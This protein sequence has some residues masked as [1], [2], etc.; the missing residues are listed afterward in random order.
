MTRH[1]AAAR[2]VARAV[3]AVAA[4]AAQP[5]S[6]EGKPTF[7]QA[8]SLQPPTTFPVDA[9]RLTFSVPDAG[10]EDLHVPADA[11]APPPPLT[12]AQYIRALDL[13][14]S[15]AGFERGSS[16]GAATA[17]AAAATG[18]AAAAAAATAVAGTSSTEVPQGAECQQMTDADVR[19]LRYVLL[20]SLAGGG[21]A[22]DFGAAFLHT[23]MAAA[24]DVKNVMPDSHGGAAAGETSALT[25]GAFH[26]AHAPP[27]APPL[28]TRAAP[29]LS[30]ARTLSRSRA[31][32]STL[33]PGLLPTIPDENASA[34]PSPQPLS[35]HLFDDSAMAEAVEEAADVEPA[36]QLTFS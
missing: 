19:L 22:G 13:V 33:L 29:P 8:I 16:G 32:D 15:F 23:V 30:L 25:E 14:A 6:A 20:Q 10:A 4:H 3:A 28:S 17:A 24:A 31:L 21:G 1:A 9:A 36:S 18:A 27:R 11:L 34:A 2:S 12:R 26:L 7:A 35:P 5:W